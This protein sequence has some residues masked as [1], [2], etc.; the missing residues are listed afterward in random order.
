MCPCRTSI[1]ISALYVGYNAPDKTTAITKDGHEGHQQQPSLAEDERR[2]ITQSQAQ[3]PL[4]TRV[5][6]NY[7]DRFTLHGSD[8]LFFVRM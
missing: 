6:D 8:P 2:D 5:I 7:V 3:L 4:A 1:F